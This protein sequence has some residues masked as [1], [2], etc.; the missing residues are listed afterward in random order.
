MSRGWSVPRGFPAT[1]PPEGREGSTQQQGAA[2]GH[3]RFLSTPG[4]SGASV[5]SLQGDSVPSASLAPP[6]VDE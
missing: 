4:A 1:L 6:H 3:R 2:I 5:L